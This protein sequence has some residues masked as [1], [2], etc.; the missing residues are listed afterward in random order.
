MIKFDLNFVNS[1][2]KQN[3]SYG[4]GCE[5]GKHMDKPRKIYIIIFFIE[6]VKDQ[7]SDK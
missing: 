5:I 2:S 6:I 7:A 3:K 4:V 1:G